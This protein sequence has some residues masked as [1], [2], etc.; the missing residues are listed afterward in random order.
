MTAEER[1]ERLEEIRSQA[2]A[3]YRLL[4]DDH[5]ADVRLQAPTPGPRRCR[6]SR[7]ETHHA[8][9]LEALD[10]RYMVR[11]GVP[12]CPARSATEPPNRTKGLSSS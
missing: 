4:L 10:L 9:L 2:D 12:V 5:A 3:A 7:E 11:S 1:I 8:V 6:V